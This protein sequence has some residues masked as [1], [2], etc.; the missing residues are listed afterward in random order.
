MSAAVKHLMYFILLVALIFVILIAWFFIVENP[1]IRSA[2]ETEEKLWIE[3]KESYLGGM[4]IIET[5]EVSYRPSPELITDGKLNNCAKYNVCEERDLVTKTI[6]NKVWLPDKSAYLDCQGSNRFISVWDQNWMEGV[7][8]SLPQFLIENAG[9]I[10]AKYCS[11]NSNLNY[12]KH[13]I[14]Y[15]QEL[16]EVYKLCTKPDRQQDLHYRASSFISPY[17]DGDAARWWDCLEGKMKTWMSVN[18]LP[19]PEIT[20]EEFKAIN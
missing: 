12:V 8:F 7:E 2:L 16:V 5:E 6:V 20:F 19:E 4:P 3:Y 9:E 13:S 11:K 17:H 1:K 14:L 15:T 18:S 10:E